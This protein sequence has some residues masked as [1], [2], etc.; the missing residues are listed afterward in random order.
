MSDLHSRLLRYCAQEPLSVL[1]RYPKSRLAAA[2]LSRSELEFL[3]TIGLP[4]SAPPMLSFSAEDGLETVEEIF[5][6][7]HQHLVI[8]S[9]GEGNPLCL[10]HELPGEVLQ[11]VLDD[12]RERFVNTSVETLAESILAFADLIDETMVTNGENALL[13]W[14]IPGRVVSRCAER[15]ESIDARAVIPGTFWNL[16]LV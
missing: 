12:G 7:P 4:N 10:S 15:I 14:N 1:V 3:C 6:L 2:R 8:G 5:G 16:A 13:N 11:V 9:D